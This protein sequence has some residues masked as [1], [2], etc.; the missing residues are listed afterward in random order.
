MVKIQKRSWIKN[1]AWEQILKIEFNITDY[2]L[3]NHILEVD[4]LK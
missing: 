2:Y 3:K 4:H 1:F